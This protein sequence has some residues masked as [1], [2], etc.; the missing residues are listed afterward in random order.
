MSVTPHPYSPEG[1][2]A[3]WDAMPGPWVKRKRGYFYRPDN[4]GYTSDILQAG[5]Y[6][7]EEAKAYCA[8]SGGEVTCVPLA[9]YR[10]DLVKAAEAA[11]AAL[12]QFDAAMSAVGEIT[13]AHIPDTKLLERAVRNSR[14]RD[15]RKGEK[16]ERWVAVMDMFNLG[17]GLAGQLC[18][19]FGLDPSEQVKR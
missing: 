16:H 12:A 1:L 14:A 7:K 3:K 10:D 4:C 8:E 6:P 2:A 18:R 11:K 19:R 15:R 5:H 13:V 17:S 9:A